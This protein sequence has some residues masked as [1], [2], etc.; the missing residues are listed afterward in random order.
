[1]NK[2]RA[3]TC[4]G[5]GITTLL[6]FILIT[7]S[8]T[9]A[10]DRLVVKDSSGNPT[11]SV[12]DTGEILGNKLSLG[13]DVT[14]GNATRSFNLVSSVAVCRF[15]RVD[16]TNHYPP[17]FDLIASDNNSDANPYNAASFF[18]IFAGAYAGADNVF[19]VMDRSGGPGGVGGDKNRIVIGPSGNVGFNLDSGTLPQ[20][21][22]E[23]AGG[24]YCDGGSWV[25]ASSRTLKQDIKEIS[26]EDALQTA[27]KLKPVNFRYKKSPAEE[28]LGFIAEDV[29]EMV[30]V[31]SRKGL[32]TMDFVAVLT[33][34]VQEQ[35][36]AIANLQREIE[37][38]KETKVAAR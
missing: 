14:S 2:R 33:K 18:S 6:F 12:S 32:E 7:C 3:F 31:N 5:L 25:N 36:K 21:P 11:F 37:M 30:A 20:H 24:A 26:Y 23:M 38:L 9:L 28:H 1:M 17:A 34:V 8:A 35:Q 16:P 29:P 27:M 19:G 10:E 22:L 13:S 4:V 15:W